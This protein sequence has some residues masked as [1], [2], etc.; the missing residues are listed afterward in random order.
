MAVLLWIYIGPELVAGIVVLVLFLPIIKVI[1]RNMLSIRKERSQLT[2]KRMQ[3]ITSMLQ[4][5][6]VTKL[7]HYEKMV[8]TSVVAVRDQEMKL[9]SR[10]LRMWGL[11]CLPRLSRRPYWRLV[12]PLL[13]LY[14]PPTTIIC[15]R[16]M[17]FGPALLFYFS[18]ISVSF[19]HFFVCVTAV[20]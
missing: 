18:I 12:W 3:I 17:F 20:E 14:S 10:E 11:W 2:D 4:G 5:I 8:E 15:A 16:Q 7:N 6:L 9:L 1:V 19:S 13:F